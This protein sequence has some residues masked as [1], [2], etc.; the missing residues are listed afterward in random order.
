MEEL[1]THLRCLIGDGG[2]PNMYWLEMSSDFLR[3]N[4]AGGRKSKWNYPS[5]GGRAP[6]EGLWQHIIGPSRI[7]WPLT[8]ILKDTMASGW[9][10][11]DRVNTLLLHDRTSG[12]LWSKVWTEH[13]LLDRIRSSSWRISGPIPE[14]PAEAIASAL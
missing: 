1:D 4:Q 13:V 12:V 7:L 3:I 5:N 10:E 2:E 8:L 9:Y 14:D 11:D 6:G